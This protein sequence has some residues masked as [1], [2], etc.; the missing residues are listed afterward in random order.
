MMKKIEVR[1]STAF[2][3]W[4]F[5]LI[6]GYVFAGFKPEAPFGALALWLTTGLGMI[7]GKRLWQKRKEFNC[8]SI[9]E[10]KK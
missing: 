4:A 6:A 8:N 10:D 7:T 9:G 2:L 3:T 5:F 1:T